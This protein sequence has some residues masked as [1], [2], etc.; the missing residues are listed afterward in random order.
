MTN[1]QNEVTNFIEQDVSIR[2][3]LT[4][5]IINTR[6]LAKYIHKNLMLS[7]SIDAVISAI[8]RYETKEEPKIEEMR[9]E[10]KEEKKETEDGFADTGFGID[11]F[12]QH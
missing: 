2:R 7:S 9:E 8:R 5:G 3:G 4:R 12:S 1:I 6:A 10:T 11:V